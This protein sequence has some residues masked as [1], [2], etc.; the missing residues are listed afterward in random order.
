MDNLFLI[1][2]EFRSLT[3]NFVN[4][5]IYLYTKRKKSTMLDVFNQTFI[6][7]VASIIG[8]YFYNIFSKI[9]YLKIVISTLLI[10]LFFLFNFT[11]LVENI[12][13]ISNNKLR[14]HNILSS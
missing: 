9:K 6:R 1:D 8:V 4:R 12:E 3:R 14:R 10:L 13:T 5:I 7:C 2:N 11:N